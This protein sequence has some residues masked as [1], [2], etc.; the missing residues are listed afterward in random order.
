MPQG[1]Y[2]LIPS[3]RGCGAGAQVGIAISGMPVDRA[4]FNATY[5]PTGEQVDGY[6]SF[7]ADSTTHLYRHPGLDQWRLASKPFDPAATACAAKI[8]AAGGPVPTGAQA[9][10]VAL[11]GGKWGEVQVTARQVDAAALAALEVERAAA[12]AAQGKRVV[13]AT[14][15]PPIPLAHPPPPAP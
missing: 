6:P 12:A 4:R 3:L 9:W 1:I 5:A 13:R 15:A 11:G 2:P 7:S 10:R 14:L 8:L